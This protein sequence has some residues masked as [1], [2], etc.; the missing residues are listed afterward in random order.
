MTLACLID[1]FC[2]TSDFVCFTRRLVGDERSNRTLT[3]DVRRTIKELG[4][5]ANKGILTCNIQIP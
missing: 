2:K 4:G 5:T 3:L 1:G